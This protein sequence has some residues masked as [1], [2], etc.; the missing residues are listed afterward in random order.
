[1]EYSEVIIPI[2]DMIN[3]G[4]YTRIAK[5]KAGTLIIGTPHKKGGF[6]FLLDGTIKQV[7]GSIEYEVSAPSV[8]ATNAGTQRIAYAVT[9]CIY[10]TVHRVEATT[11]EEAEIEL[12][13]G[14]PQITRIR[15]SYKALIARHGLD[16]EAVVNSLQ[17]CILEES[18]NFYLAP[19]PVN[20]TGVFAKK[21]F[22]PHTCIT[23][24]V[25]N[26]QRLSTSRYV[27][28]SDIPN[29]RFIDYNETS[30]ALVST[31][32]IQKDMEIFIDYGERGIICHQQ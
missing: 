7:D 14:E 11:C 21:D 29:A 8:I 19:S 13:E 9:D 23:M 22:D 28:H 18:D 30:I 16:E 26:E 20:G 17:P 24:A 27:N 32:F 12:F 3:A 10:S 2:E 6:A 4:I 15:N 25:I 5:A 31:K 1:M